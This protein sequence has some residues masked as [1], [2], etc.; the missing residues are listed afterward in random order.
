MA[1]HEQVFEATR[2]IVYVVSLFDQMD[3]L[4]FK[5]LFLV[6]CVLYL[7]KVAQLSLKFQFIDLRSVNQSVKIL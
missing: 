7:L 4:E 5:F 6:L 2:L 1:N 3:H